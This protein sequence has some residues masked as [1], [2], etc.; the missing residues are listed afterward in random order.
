MKKKLLSKLFLG[1][2]AILLF[3]FSYQKSHAQMFELGDKDLNI[4]LGLGSTFYTGAGWSTTLPPLSLS[5]DYGFK[6]DVGPGVIGLGGYLGVASHKWEN[7]IFTSWGWKYTTIVVA[8]RGT[9]HMDFIEN[10]DTYGGVH[11]GLRYSSSKEIG[12][13][14]G[15]ISEDGAYLLF[16]LFVGG[17]YYVTEN[18]AILGELGYSVAWL[19]IGATFKL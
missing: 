4:G 12:T 1:L 11:L 9:Y 7:T 17:K 16:N 18:I 14:V 2:T 15:G 3:S 10:F 19:T 5:M 6:D 8:A 13:V